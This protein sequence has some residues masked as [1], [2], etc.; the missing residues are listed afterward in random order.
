MRG[1]VEAETCRGGAAE[2]E[3]EEEEQDAWKRRAHGE[4]LSSED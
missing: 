4:D 3:E 2:K 1:G